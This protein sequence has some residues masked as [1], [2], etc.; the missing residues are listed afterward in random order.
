VTRP[1]PPPPSTPSASD[2]LRVYLLGEVEFEAA[3]ALQKTLVYETAGARHESSLVLCEHPPLITVG[4]HG[5]PGDIRCGPE[6]LRARRWRVRWV[7]R[8]GGC[9]LHAP[10]QLAVYAVVPL[11]RWGLG[12]EAYLQRLRRVVI[13]VL[14]DFGVRGESS[15][16]GVWAGGRLLAGCGVAVC[17]WVAYYGAVVN[18]YPDLN[19]FRLVRGGG[20]D[21]G[22]MTS[23]ARERKGPLRA[24]LVRQRFVE[25]FQAAFPSERTALFSHHPALGRA[26]SVAVSARPGPA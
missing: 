25:H 1:H 11:D 16:A 4:R 21:D 5:G 8:G 6:E 14:D 26:E 22:P 9:W 23:L 3:L 20:P 2:V 7:N 13:D 17:D 12:V 15:P 24:A 19:H 18:V 10:G